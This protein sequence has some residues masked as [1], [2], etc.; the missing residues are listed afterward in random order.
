MVTKP[1]T[2][3]WKESASAVPISP[4]VIYLKHGKRVDSHVRARWCG[5]KKAELMSKTKK[6][7][8]PTEAALAAIEE[9]LKLDNLT[10]G[11]DSAQGV[12]A[13]APN[14]DGASAGMGAEA[15]SPEQ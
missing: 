15:R 11:T 2:T 7:V 14:G 1:L 5:V 13:A 3:F 6:V 10:S 4:A 12:S 8:D 9:A